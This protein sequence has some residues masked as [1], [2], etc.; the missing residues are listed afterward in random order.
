MLSDLIVKP[1]HD[2]CA[3]DADEDNGEDDCTRGENLY[4]FVDNY[5]SSEMSNH[6][7]Q[8]ATIAATLCK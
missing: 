4:D 8:R 2:D 1:V 3:K 7:T 5:Q 6:N